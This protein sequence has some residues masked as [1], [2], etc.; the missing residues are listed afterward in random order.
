[1]FPKC[2]KFGSFEITGSSLV[3]PI[4]YY[5]FRNMFS[6]GH[7]LGVTHVK[8]KQPLSNCS[9]IAHSTRKWFGTF[10]I[11]GSNITFSSIHV[12]C[13]KAIIVTLWSYLELKMHE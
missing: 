13:L 12:A 8:Q 4:V 3:F 1:M 2:L 9:M 11:T 6:C 5:R 7:F 10:E